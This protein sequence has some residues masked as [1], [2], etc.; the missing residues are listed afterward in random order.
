DF[1][2]LH[3]DCIVFDAHCD[4]LNDVLAGTRQL[5]ERSQLGEVDI[6]RLREGGVTA[7]IFACWVPVEF[8]AHSATRHALQL[9]DAFYRELEANPDTLMLALTSDDILRAKAEGRVAGILGLE[10]AEALDGSI[11]LL[12]IFH[13]LGLRNLGLAWNYRN[14]AC[15]GVMVARSRGGLTPFGEK[16]VRECNRL[17]IMI[18][19]AHVAPVGVE[20]V[21]ALSEQPVICSHANAY[22]LCPN[23]R[24]LTDAQIEAIAAN[25]GV[26]GATFVREFISPDSQEASLERFLDHVDHLVKIAGVDHVGLGSDFDGLGLDGP[27][28]GMED[29][30]SYP[31]VTAGLLTRGY[32]ERSIR[33]IMGENL[34]RIFRSVC[35]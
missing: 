4:A 6:P 23:G 26:I 22:A 25:G 21:L 24:N 8:Q 12:R 33:K 32:D 16:L 28:D 5:G 30:T 1:N 2:T 14:A 29:V 19:V 9:V 15:D 27:P 34:L 11:E 10:G 18:D 3:Y 20:D 7:Q 35:G 17:G 31:L 13:R